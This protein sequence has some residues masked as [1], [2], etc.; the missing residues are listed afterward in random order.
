[1]N[2]TLK[3]EHDD[4]LLALI[5]RPSRG[6]HS[7]VQFFTPPHLSQQV[8]FM[9]HNSGHRIDAH[10]HNP[11]HR[12]VKLTQEVLIIERGVLRVDFYTESETYLFSHRV[13]AGDI[14]VLVNGGHG[15]KVLEPLHMIEIKQGP[16]I[17]DATDKTRF[18]HVSDTAVIL[19]D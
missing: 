10:V 1:M 9:S 15:F 5:I 4:Q 16:Y 3:V 7:G 14:L 12:D 11:V 8:A 19:R 13:Q 17:S 2:E 6:Q 18:P